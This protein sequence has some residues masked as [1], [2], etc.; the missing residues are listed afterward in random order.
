MQEFMQ[1]GRVYKKQQ[2]HQNK[3]VYKLTISDRANILRVLDAMLPS[4]LV[5]EEE[6]LALYAYLG[7]HPGRSSPLRFKP[8]HELS[9]EQ[10]HQWYIVEGQSC[11]TIAARYGVTPSGIGLLLKRRGIPRRK[12]GEGP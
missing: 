12:T 7:E 2:S 4:L 11:A 1:T 5:K 8:L 6:A 3:S 10:L 9:T